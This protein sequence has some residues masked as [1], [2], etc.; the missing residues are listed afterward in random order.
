VLDVA[1]QLAKLAELSDTPPIIRL[2]A[3]TDVMAM[4]VPEDE[5]DWPEKLFVW[6]R[7][8]VAEAGKETDAKT[9]KRNNACFML[10][11]TTLQFR[12]IAP[13]VMLEAVLLH[14]LKLTLFAVGYLM[15]VNIPLALGAYPVTPVGSALKSAMK[16]SVVAVPVA[17]VVTAAAQA[18]EA[19]APVPNADVPVA[20]TCVAVAL[21]AAVGIVTPLI[22]V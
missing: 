1:E 11:R 4:L 20:I 17:V 8:K 9:P 16:L 15:I 13:G 2:P 12:V 7:V 14:T 18:P 6:P 3:G 19:M 10:Y 21:P 5:T 22:E